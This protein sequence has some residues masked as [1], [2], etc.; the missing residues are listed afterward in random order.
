MSNIDEPAGPIPGGNDNFGIPI[1][2]LTKREY[3]CI[4]CGVPNTGDRELDAIIAEGNR[5]KLE[6]FRPKWNGGPR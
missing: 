5:I 3:A 4:H 1:L 6:T 2:G